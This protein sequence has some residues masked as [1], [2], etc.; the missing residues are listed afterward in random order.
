MKTLAGGVGA[1]L[2][3]EINVGREKLPGYDQNDLLM[4]FRGF[5]HAVE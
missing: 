4:I 2:E 1:P 3:F 5:D